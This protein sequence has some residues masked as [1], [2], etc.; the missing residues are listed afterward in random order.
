MFFLLLLFWI[1]FN[2]RLALDVLLSGVL[3][4]VAITWF[5]NRYCKWDDTKHWNWVRFLPRML[6]Y[7]GL[8]ISEIFKTNLEMI[9]MILTP[10]DMKEIIHPQMVKIP[11][12]LKSEFTRMLLANSITLTPGTI[13]VRLHPD[14]YVIHALTPDMA[15]EDQESPFLIACRGLDEA[16]C[17]AEP[18][19]EGK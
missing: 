12:D 18:E 4:S 13:T 19:K 9:R 2:G 11:V 3:V 16:I 10:K 17:P 5:A 7:C 8:L 15:A 1:I 6:A 14:T